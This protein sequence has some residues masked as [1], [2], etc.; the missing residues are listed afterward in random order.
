MEDK[1]NGSANVE[2]LGD[3]D[4]TFFGFGSFKKGVKPSAHK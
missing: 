1:I 2:P 3:Y 4:P